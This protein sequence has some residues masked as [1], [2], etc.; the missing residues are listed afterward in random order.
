MSSFA[1]RLVTV[2]I[3]GTLTRGHGWRSIAERFDRLPAYEASNRRFFAHEV[4][5]DQHLEELLDLATGRSVAEVLEAVA[6][7]PHLDGIADGVARLRAD[8][9]HVAL[10][11]HN[12]AY[13]AEWYAKTYGFEAF[14]GVV[15]PPI[16]S[17]RLSA[18]GRVHADKVEGV[19]RLEERFGV[20]ARST[21]HVGDSWADAAV[22]AHVG[23]G[24][25]L[26]S[27]V[28]DVDRAADLVLRTDDFRVVAAAVGT[29]RPRP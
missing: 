17:G 1:W 29:L 9:A 6:A 28:P 8:G 20:D 11:T 21:V 23:G 14:D 27:A 13:V 10:L 2:D 25:A 4:G 5:E 12:P 24:V 16:V 15:S 19:A 7:T 22:F 26:N 3:D 18:P